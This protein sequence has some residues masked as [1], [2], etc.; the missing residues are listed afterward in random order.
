MHSNPALKFVNANL[1][2]EDTTYVYYNKTSNKSL[3]VVASA[4]CR[5]VEKTIV[6]RSLP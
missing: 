4:S 2:T 5:E 1:L 3:A 6:H